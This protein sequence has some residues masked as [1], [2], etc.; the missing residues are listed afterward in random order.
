MALRVSIGQYY[1]ADSPI[2][3][4]DPRVKL[5][6]TAAFMLSCLLAG[7]AATL[8]LA[9]AAV[10]ASAAAARVP[11]R[12]L[13]AQVRPL[14][15]FLAVTSLINLLFTHTGTVVAELGALRIYSDG[16]VAAARY[17]IRFLLLLVAGSLLM[18]TTTPVDL[19]DAIEHLLA[20]LARIGVP[21]GE[22]ALTLS[23]ALHFV[24]LLSQEAHAVV[25]AQIARGADLETKGPIAYA[26]ACV[27]LAV[28]LFASALRHAESLGRALEARCYTGGAGRTHARE[29]HMGVRRDGPFIIL[30]VLYLAGVSA[31]AAAGL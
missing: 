17:T 11:A 23:I 18:L 24:P 27:P 26:R 19:T 10:A 31:L 29:L 15:I 7:S 28:P 13:L 2:H 6:A 14:A 12:R 1:S 9:A 3:S 16:A 21:V 22:G 5:V 25:A 8:T 30:F 20:P 4:L